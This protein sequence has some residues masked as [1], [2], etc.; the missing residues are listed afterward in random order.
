MLEFVNQQKFWKQANTYF[1]SV[2]FFSHG[3]IEI[4]FGLFWFFKFCFEQQILFIKINAIRF[5]L[6]ED[7]FSL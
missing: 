5:S 3:L 2:L 4:P 7:I 6:S 1:L